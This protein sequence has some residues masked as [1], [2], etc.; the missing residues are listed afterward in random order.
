MSGIAGILQLDGA[1]VDRSLLETMTHYLAQ[2]GP[3]AQEIWFDGPVGFG[4]AM[5]RTTFEQAREQQPSSLDGQVWITAD[6]RID[7]RAELR[8]ELQAA[9][10]EKVED[11]TDVELIL[12]AYRA[13][14][15]A[16]VEH[17]LGDF[18]FAIWDGREH[19]LFCARDH[20]G[21]KPFYYAQ[22][23]GA[24]IFANTLECVRLHPAVSSELNE[25]A[26]ADFLLFNLNRETDTT[27]F[28]DIHQLSPAHTLTAYDG[29]LRMR[30]FWTLPI[31]ETLY[32]KQPDEYVDHFRELFD[33]AV[34][35]RLRT[36]RLGIFMSGGLDST[37]VASVARRLLVCGLDKSDFRA[38]TFAYGVA[39]PDGEPYHAALVSQRLNMPNEVISADEY[40]TVESWED[41]AL[42]TPEPINRTVR[43]MRLDAMRRAAEHGRV[44]LSGYGADPVLYPSSGHFIGLAKKLRLG[45]MVSDVWGYWH[46]VGRRPPL[47]IGTYLRQKLGMLNPRAPYPTWLN[48]TFADRLGLQARWQQVERKPLP[49]HLE[50]AEAHAFLADPMWQHRFVNLDAGATQIPLEMRHPFF[51]VRLIAYL[52]RLPPVPWFVHKYLLRS[53]MHGVL[54]EAIRTRPKSSFPIGKE[55]LPTR[56]QVQAWALDLEKTPA[57]AAWVD[58]D[59]YRSLADRLPHTDPYAADSISRPPSFARW[60]WAGSHRA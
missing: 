33:R 14:G 50:R 18:A 12:H 53:A 9:G 52:L 56:E 20:F 45:R 11:A 3:D 5:L 4:H 47:Y 28:A 35:D 44:L 16:C 25:L 21:V 51:D 23:G 17:L 19:K 22:V 59:E 43:A 49:A 57:I 2:R 8:R 29:S 38:Y 15:E 6:A 41:R 54:P 42:Q 27:I 60:L 37:S 7:G 58:V 31:E 39:A 48:P 24:L 34:G 30:Q 46:L 13:W 32:Y 55:E 40:E 26:V 1:P 36:E 10:R